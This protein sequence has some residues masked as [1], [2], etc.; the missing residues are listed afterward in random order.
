MG[1]SAEN[2]DEGAMISGA[3][4]QG[5]FLL[6]RGGARPPQKIARGHQ[7]DQTQEI[8]KTHALTPTAFTDRE[9]P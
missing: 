9:N 1:K 2:G 5:F 4:M 3:R 8:Q 6:S 7:Q